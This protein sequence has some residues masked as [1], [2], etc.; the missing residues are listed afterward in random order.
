[1]NT[2]LQD[3][4][5]MNET[6]LNY[7]GFHIL[8]KGIKQMLLVSEAHFFDQPVSH[9]KEQ[10]GVAPEIRGTRGFKVFSTACLATP[11]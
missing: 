1:M 11:M 8:P 4:Q 3:Q 9:R 7:P 5:P 6:I 2:T 10:K